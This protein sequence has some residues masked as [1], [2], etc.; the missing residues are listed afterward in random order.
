MRRLIIVVAGILVCSILSISQAVPVVI[1]GINSKSVNRTNDSFELFRQAQIGIQLLQQQGHAALCDK[2]P[3]AYQDVNEI[4]II[5]G[6]FTRPI[7]D[8]VAIIMPYCSSDQDYFIIGIIEKGK[9]LAATFAA[10]SRCSVTIEKFPD[11]NLNGT[12]ELMINENGGEACMSSF[13]NL[14]DFNGNKVSVLQTFDISEDAA[15]CAFLREYAE[16]HTISVEKGRQPKFFINS[17]KDSCKTSGTEPVL[18]QKLV[19]LKKSNAMIPQL[20]LPAVQPSALDYATA[21]HP[22]LINTSV[23]LLTTQLCKDLS[24]RLTTTAKLPGNVTFLSYSISAKRGFSPTALFSYQINGI[25]KMIGFYSTSQS[26]L[27]S[28]NLGLPESLADRLILDATGQ[29]YTGASTEIYKLYDGV[30]KFNSSTD[31]S[32]RFK[33]LIISNMTALKRSSTQE[34]G[35]FTVGY[36]ADPVAFMS[37]NQ[38]INRTVSQTEISKAE[39]DFV[40]SQ[41][42]KA[43]ATSKCKRQIAPDQDAAPFQL[44]QNYFRSRNYVETIAAESEPS[45][46]T[47]PGL[48]G[49]GVVVGSGYSEEVGLTPLCLQ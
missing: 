12:N 25:H 18:V 38:L 20:T 19:P 16:S 37:L 10:A 11:V 22:K 15:G 26:A 14:V 7:A 9:I 28:D 21:S 6:S 49:Q 48:A 41:K 36:I 40:T 29:K 33:G 42:L 24:C 35:P 2:E 5:N 46:F 4:E 17:Y 45:V 8:Q 44:W 23:N 3:N 30:S 13:G 27:D 34:Y 31:F 1:T 39:A 32:L 43:T 47:L